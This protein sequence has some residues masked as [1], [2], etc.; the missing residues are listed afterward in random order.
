MLAVFPGGWSLESA[1]AISD[2]DTDV[3]NGMTTLIDH[4]LVRRIEHVDGSTRY[5]M[6]ETIREFGL[7]QLRGLDEA[8]EIYRRFLD[9]LL[10]A[11]SE[12]ERDWHTPHVAGWLQRGD[13]EKENVRLILEW[14][15]TNDPSLAGLRLACVFAWFWFMRGAV[16][17][18]QRWLTQG[19]AKAGTSRTICEPTCC[20]RL[21]RM[22]R[23]WVTS[24]SPDPHKTRLGP[25]TADL[26]DEVGVGTCLHGLG[27]IAH[28]SGD[29]D[30]AVALV[31]Q[32]AAEILRRHHRL[33]DSWSRFRI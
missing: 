3:L 21:D 23:H 4:N 9:Y 10:H 31:P 19:L 20:G 27:Q 11:F 13:V 16:P 32:A 12:S 1:E 2:P 24:R 18:S 22:R 17:E 14:A 7:Q 6:L 30:Q 26:G 33:H 29:V 25:S 8:D 15:G 5:G 28:F